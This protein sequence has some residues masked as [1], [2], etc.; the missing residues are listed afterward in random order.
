[1]SVTE[2][3]TTPGRRTDGATMRVIVQDT[4]GSTDVLD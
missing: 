1:M 2:E 4:Y 3:I